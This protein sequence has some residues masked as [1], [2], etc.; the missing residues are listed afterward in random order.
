[1]SVNLPN[2]FTVQ[3]STRVELLLQEKGSK[4]RPFLMSGTHV[5]KQA[6]PVNQVGAIV[7][8][9][10]V[11]R[12]E[13]KTRTDAVLTRRWV[14][15]SSFE[16]NQMIDSF[17]ELRTIVDPKAQ[18]AENAALAFGR[19]IDDLIITAATGTSNTGE[20]GSGTE[21]YD[22]AASTSGGAEVAA[23]FGASASVGLTVAK[24]IELKRVFRSKFVDIEG[25]PLTL[26]MGSSQEANL[27]NQTEVVSTEFND[28]PVLVDGS[29]KKFLG[30][31]FVVSER[32][33]LA[34]AG[35]RRVISFAKSGMYLGVW[36]DMESIADRRID[37]QSN[38]WQLTTMATWGATRLQQYK[39]T[40]ALC[41]E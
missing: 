30:F 41:A 29:V 32:L 31:N 38:P 9:P 27:L 18:Y 17:D 6:S 12:F 13:P 37:L 23:A 24:M 34:S 14:F 10:V 22:T 8:S 1:M 3:F 7:A 40:S 11:S 36:K 33:T 19:Q 16:T 35:V 20:T 21:S 39:V 4:L 28:R 25:D 15:P 26:V 5:G 2:I